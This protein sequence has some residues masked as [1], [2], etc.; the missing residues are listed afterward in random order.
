MTAQN[1]KTALLIVGHS[2]KLPEPYLALKKLA[3]NLQNTL[4]AMKVYSACILGET[5]M[6]SELEK[7]TSHRIERILV[8]PYFLTNGVHFSR[9]LPEIILK[10][11]KRNPH[12]QIKLLSTLQGESGI[13]DILTDKVL[14]QSD[15]QD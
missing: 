6:A 8:L 13:V 14:A 11:S 7:I 4:P 3:E 5:N 2:S 15:W 9:D 12:A 1:N 10:F